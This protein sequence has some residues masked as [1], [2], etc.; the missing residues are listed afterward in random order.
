VMKC[1][2]ELALVGAASIAWTAIAAFA[3]MCP[4]RTSSW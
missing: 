2:A 1:E 3:K 4:P